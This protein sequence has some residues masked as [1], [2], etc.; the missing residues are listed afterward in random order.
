MAKDRESKDLASGKKGAKNKPAKESHSIG[1]K[2]VG[3]LKGVVQELKRVTWPT[4]KEMLNSGII[5]V[6]TLIFFALFT[7]AFDSASTKGV[8]ALANTTASKETTA[9]PKAPAPETTATV[10]PTPSATATETGQ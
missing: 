6:V 9:T 3:Y 2:I 7:F 8:T 10:T 1:G 4:P 5:V